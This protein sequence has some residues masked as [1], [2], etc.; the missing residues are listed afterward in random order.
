MVM[1]E[2]TSIFIVDDNK[3]IQVIN[4]KLLEVLGFEVRGLL[5]TEK[6]PLKCSIHLILSQILY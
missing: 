5:A 4:K 3:D 1:S 2:I 6:R